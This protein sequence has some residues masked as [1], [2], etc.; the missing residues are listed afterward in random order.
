MKNKRLDQTLA[1]NEVEYGCYIDAY[2]QKVY[3]NICCTITARVSASND[4]FV[5][6]NEEDMSYSNGSIKRIKKNIIENDVAP[7][8]TANAMQSINHQNCALIKVGNYGNG[9]HAKDVYDAEGVSPTIVTGNHGLGQT[10][11]IKNATKKGYLEAENGDGID[12]SGRMQHHRGTVQKGITQTLNTR[13][14]RYRHDAK[15]KN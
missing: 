12:I 3:K 7:T 13:G 4:Y 2:N 9:H 8:I 10:I 11:A 1:N 15:F 6:V 14:G 5:C